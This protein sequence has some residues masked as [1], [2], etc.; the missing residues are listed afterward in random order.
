MMGA[1]KAITRNIWDNLL[2]VLHLL[3][4]TVKQSTQSLTHVLIGFLSLIFNYFME[5]HFII[6]ELVF[7]HSIVSFP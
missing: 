7:Y 4:M 3:S 5:L 6:F 2:C 1:T